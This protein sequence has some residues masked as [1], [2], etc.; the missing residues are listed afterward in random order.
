MRGLGWGLL[1]A[2]VTGGGAL[3]ADHDHQH[4]HD[5]TEKLGTVR[6]ATSCR[7]ES[8][9]AFERGVALMHSFGYAQAAEAF[10]HV[11]QL[12][13]TCAMAQWGLAMS[14]YHPI[15]A[16]PTPDELAAGQ[17]AVDR[18]LALAATAGSSISPRERSYL[19]TIAVFYRDVATL[20]HLERAKRYAD[21]AGNTAKLYADD[22]EAS[23][24]HALAILGIAYASPP[25][26]DYPLQKQAAA[27]LNGLLP[28][29]PDHPG[30]AHYMIHAF[31]YPELA[32]LALPAAQAYAA[33]APDSSH[34]QHMPSHIFVRL[35]MWREAIASNLAS[36]ETDI[37]QQRARAAAAGL[38]TPPTGFNQLHAVDYLAYAYLQTAQ[39]DKARALVDLA[40]R[41][42]ALDAP[43][44]SAGYAL[45]AVP[46]RYAL[47]RRRFADAAALP[48]LPSLFP[49]S[50]HP[51]S[52]AFLHFARAV[53]AARSGQVAVA[54]KALGRLNELEQQLLAAPKGGFDWAP[55]VRAQRLAASAWIAEADG[56]SIEA[57]RQ[58]RLAADLEDGL[59]KHPVTPG[60]VL[61]A[62]EQLG[63]LE[64][65]LGEPTVALTA[66][67]AVL[68]ASPG[69][70]NAVAGAAK[71]AEASGQAELAVGYWKELAALGELAEVV[72]PELAEARAKSR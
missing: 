67:Q 23:I 63:D 35:G 57:R 44:F 18:G 25:D 50:N 46:A 37:R 8:A 34:A 2:G 72:R 13:P 22:A 51:G 70:F 9:T 39:D 47:E 52:E 64:L 5:S 17:A 71:A 45:A 7:G 69:R 48:D 28:A 40:T 6:F 3:A 14:Y 60:A 43:N 49:W 21:A 11:A 12:D 53:G 55:H 62:R 65:A 58:M 16:P 33:I 36:A 10:R 19:D 56:N 24:F 4:H 1:L 27:I 59:D 61:P 26:K 54:K 20:P 66:Y 41:V 38:P 68:V 15:W 29:H 31:D 30:I 42:T 32:R